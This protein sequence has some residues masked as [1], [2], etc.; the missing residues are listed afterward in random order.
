MSHLLTPFIHSYCI[1]GKI[2]KTI[3]SIV[4]KDFYSEKFNHYILELSLQIL[5]NIMRHQS[6][7]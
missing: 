6:Y 1:N 7:R 3:L 4:I 5:I 2:L